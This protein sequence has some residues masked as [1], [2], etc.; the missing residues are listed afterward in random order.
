MEQ[1]NTAQWED[2]IEI[3]DIYYQYKPLTT[4]RI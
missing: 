3:W 2:Y 4:F 1:F